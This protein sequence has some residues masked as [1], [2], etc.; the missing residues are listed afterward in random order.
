MGETFWP[1]IRSYF[2]YIQDL[3]HK[4]NEN[5]NF[6]FSDFSG[7]FLLESEDSSR[8]HSRNSSTGSNIPTS[9]IV[10]ETYVEP[11]QQAVNGGVA[12]T[13]SYHALQNHENHG[14]ASNLAEEA[15][16][17]LQQSDQRSS[18]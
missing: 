8:H 9:T 13:G 3:K 4:K 11:E 1:V 16:R 10:V 5:L 12:S 18:E 7:K 17:L 6:F 15:E 14:V 2:L